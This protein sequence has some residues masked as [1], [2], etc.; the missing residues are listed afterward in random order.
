MTKMKK[1]L[2]MGVTLIMCLWFFTGCGSSHNI[3][4]GEYVPTDVEMS[5]FNLRPEGNTIDYFWRIKGGNADFYVSGAHT[6][7][8]KII[9]KEGKMYFEGRTWFDIFSWRELGVVF[10]YE[11][12]YD[13]STKSITVITKP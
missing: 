13:E 6:Y 3:P 5:H 7:K 9:V 1:N 11:I 12:R 4:N 10:K 8:C 2:I